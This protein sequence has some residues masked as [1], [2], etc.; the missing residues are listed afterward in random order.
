MHREPF[1]S[2]VSVSILPVSGGDGRLSRVS[3]LAVSE[4]RPPT[5][6]ATAAS[7]ATT[8]TAV[9][10]EQ[11]ESNEEVLQQQ[12]AAATATAVSHEQSESNE[13][14]EE[15]LLMQQQLA[16]LLVPVLQSDGTLAPT[17]RQ[18]SAARAAI[19]VRHPQWPSSL[20][21]S[22]LCTMH[23]HIALS[24]L[25]CPSLGA[26]VASLPAHRS[27]ALSRYGSS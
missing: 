5:A 24:P 25:P 16:A 18:K 2:A 27:L 20:C 10:H 21:K 9:S 14:D 13:R 12:L 6:A 15:V 22:P 17:E 1:A 3:I 8:A 26:A 23:A 4:A 11:S 19:G 7:T